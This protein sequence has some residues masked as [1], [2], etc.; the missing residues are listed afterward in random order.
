MDRELVVLPGTISLTQLTQHVTLQVK[1][2]HLRQVDEK[3]AK[4]LLIR[5][6][7]AR[8]PLAIGI[9]RIPS[10]AVAELL[11]VK[12]KEIFQGLLFEVQEDLDQFGILGAAGEFFKWSVPARVLVD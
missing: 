2:H 9:A 12:L 7:R 6:D 1:A 5:P 8:F 3:P 11:T 10:S 4:R